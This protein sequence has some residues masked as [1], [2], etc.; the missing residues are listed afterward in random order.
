MTTTPALT[1]D[2]G[3]A[4]RTLRALLER[5]LHESGLSFSDWTVLV[6]LDGA[7]LLAGSE[8]IQRQVDGRVAPEAAART[9]VDGLR[10]SGLIA[11]ADETA[12][13]AARSTEGG[14]PLLTLTPAGQAVYQPVR[15]S[16]LRIT[17]ELYG[18]LAPADLEAT[19]RTLAEVA[20]RAHDLLART[21]SMNVSTAP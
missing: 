19:H 15:Q 8:L 1:R 9:S 3:Q 5:T 6:F 4:E 14:D 12:G 7:G 10:T 2:I 13:P 17:G 16:V 18:D 20:R 11:T 21:G